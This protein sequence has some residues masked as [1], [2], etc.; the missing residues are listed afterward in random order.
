MPGNNEQL[1]TLL[2]AGDSRG[3]APPAIIKPQYF[4][5][6]EVSDILT[7]IDDLKQYWSALRPTSTSAIPTQ[8]LSRGMPTCS[9][10]EY[11]FNVREMKEIMY[12]N[13]STYYEKI[14]ETIEKE[15]GLPTEFNTD[16]QYPGFHIFVNKTDEQQ[17][18]STHNFHKDIFPSLGNIMQVGDI[19]S[20]IIPLS[21]PSVGGNLLY[22][23]N[24]GPLGINVSD[25]D[26]FVYNTGDM[27]KWPN[28]LLHSI[29]P[30]TLFPNERRITC[31]MHLN[32]LANKIIIFW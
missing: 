24:A 19:I 32:V 7:R 13:F 6:D 27:I 23:L 30:F 20:V 4:T 2:K 28:K 14:I 26:I 16:C 3:V 25:P 18:Y 29:E 12:H 8:L 21:I 31:Q 10:L 5:V 22:K 9:P 17:E 11:T 15:F 1:I